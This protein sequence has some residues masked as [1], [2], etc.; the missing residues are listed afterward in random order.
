MIEILILLT[1]K[2]FVVDAL[3]QTPYQYLNKGEF[4]HPGGILHA[5]LH[6]LATIACFYSF[7]LDMM[8][9]HGFVDMII[10]YF[11]DYAKMNIGRKFKWSEYVNHNFGDSYLRI[12]SN[13]FFIILVLDQCLHFATYIFLVWFAFDYQQLFYP[14][15]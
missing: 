8:L 7:N 1:I 9:M 2:H 13:N 6:G 15:G 10:H 11:I 4:L 5:G 14:T 12:N 3:L